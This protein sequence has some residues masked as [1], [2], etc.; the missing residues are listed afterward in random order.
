MSTTKKRNGTTRKRRSSLAA[1]SQRHTTD[2]RCL[3]LSNDLAENIESGTRA[4]WKDVARFWQTE[5]AK[6][7]HRANTLA[8]Q[9]LM[10]AL[11]AVRWLYDSRGEKGDAAG[12]IGNAG[13]ELDEL[14]LRRAANTQGVARAAQ[15]KTDE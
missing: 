10:N 9:S 4:E 12:W 2:E 6:E 15:N 11:T 5:H 8:N 1:G 3:Q 13:D 7:I 14:L